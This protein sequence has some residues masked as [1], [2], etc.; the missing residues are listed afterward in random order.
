LKQLP[1]SASAADEEG[2]VAAAEAGS[3]AAAKVVGDIVVAVAERVVAV[4]VVGG[5]ASWRRA[6]TAVAAPQEEGL[7]WR[8]PSRGN[9]LQ[10]DPMPSSVTLALMKGQMARLRRGHLQRWRTQ[11]E[12][13]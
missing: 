7:V 12:S 13:H 9:Y 6:G 1:S 3:I 10:K 11:V 5:S 2:T 4:A 8:S